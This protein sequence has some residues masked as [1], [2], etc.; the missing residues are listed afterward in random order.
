MLVAVI[1]L[2]LGHVASPSLTAATSL[3]L[4]AALPTAT[5]GAV[6]ARA[7]PL[8]SLV[9]ARVPFLLCEQELAGVA[10]QLGAVAFLDRSESANELFHRQRPQIEEGLDGADDLRVPRRDDPQEFLHHTHLL[11]IVA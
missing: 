10:L 11:R 7:L 3:W 5:S 9:L 6:G 4:A 2:Y 8:L 1:A